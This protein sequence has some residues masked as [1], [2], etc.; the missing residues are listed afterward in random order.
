MGLQGFVGRAIPHDLLLRLATAKR[1]QAR[2]KNSPS[3][4][5]VRQ[6]QLDL[7][8]SVLSK[9]QL[10]FERVMHRGEWWH[11]V[12]DDEAGSARAA[13]S[14]RR[15]GT[16]EVIN[17]PPNPGD[18]STHSTCR[19][20]DSRELDPSSPYAH[21]LGAP[22][23]FNLP[24]DD[25]DAP[26]AMAVGF[27][28]DVVYTW[29]DGSDPE[30]L[31]QRRS[32]AS[33]WGGSHLPTA[34]DEGRFASNDELKFSLRSVEAFAPWV[35]HV[36]LVT[37]GQVPAWLNEEAPGLTVIDHRE[38]FAEQASLPTF[39]S[40]AIEANLHR[41][42]GLEEHFI[43][44]NDDVF[45]GRSAEPET[46]YVSGGAA[47]FFPGRNFWESGADALPVDVAARNN[48][49]ALL[50]ISGKGARFK[51]KHTMHAQIRS[52]LKALER[53]LPEE[54]ETTVAAKF[55]SDADLSIPS[56]LAHYFGLLSGRAVP[57]EVDYQY[58]DCGRAD[59]RMQ[60][61]RLLF[62][63]PVQMFCLNEVTR[64]QAD[65]RSSDE[66]RRTFLE[67]YFPLASRFELP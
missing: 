35:N 67:S 56:A 44:A 42:P 7:A 37:A 5:A 52:T 63:K 21:A 49:G 34:N 8:S 1:R 20:V 46:F 51:M 3:L 40:H 12:N 28:I 47:R 6:R 4:N 55:R 15:R 65:S 48:N 39:N 22:I 25:S 43:Y 18:L 30:W 33:I 53:K 29:V 60:L 66:A 32:A 13:L 26:D 14:S 9:L 27:P 31:R 24:G 11:V 57:S 62:K 10:S 58:V 64:N 45:L 2:L 41:I 36:Y 16:Y 61:A 50:R 19:L 59:V 38:I 23:A 54:V 17:T